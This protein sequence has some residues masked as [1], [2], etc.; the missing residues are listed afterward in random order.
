VA[1]LKPAGGGTDRPVCAPKGEYAN[2]LLCGDVAYFR[3]PEVMHLI[4]MQRL[5]GM[6]R[7]V[8][9]DAEVAIYFRDG[10]VAFVTG[11]ERG[12]AEQ[13]G[14]MLV[15]MGR[16]TEEEL[17]DSLST[18]ERTGGRLGKTLV[19]AGHAEEASIIS[20]LTKQTERSVYKAMGWSEGRFEFGLCRMPDFV[21]EFPL[22]LR[23]EGLLLEG[24]RRTKQMRLVTER[25]PSLDIVFSGPI[26]E[27]ETFL[28]MGLSEN[29]M[30]V[31][32]I[33]DGVRIVSDVIDESGLGEFAALKALNALY[34]AG[35]IKKLKKTTSDERT[36]YL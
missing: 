27:P 13:L 20:A 35:L 17:K 14:R 36:G 19:Q 34:T 3:T 30:K 2:L 5:T 9:S 4:A 33:V 7:L 15:G 8:K 21:E 11:M 24:M 31:V 18:V 32:K 22:G 29:E 6:L 12:V 10:D 28:G 26:G 1:G 23:V 25:I 16:I